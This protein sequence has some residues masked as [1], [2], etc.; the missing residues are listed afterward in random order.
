M[1]PDPRSAPLGAQLFSQISRASLTTDF[2]LPLTGAA[3]NRFDATPLCG[4]Y[5]NGDSCTTIY[6]DGESQMRA[7]FAIGP[8]AKSTN[9]F[10]NRRRATCFFSM[11]RSGGAI[12]SSPCAPAAGT[13][14]PISG[15]AT[16]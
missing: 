13:R 2:A 6:R 12:S 15:T 3:L 4:V 11:H 10:C 5:V 16:K 7:R 9:A 8:A 1:S 14:S